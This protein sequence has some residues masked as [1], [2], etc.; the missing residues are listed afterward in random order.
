M[1]SFRRSNYSGWLIDGEALLAALAA[2][3]VVP[4]HPRRYAEHVTHRYP[5]AE[6]APEVTSIAVVGHAADAEVDCVVVEV[7]LPGGEPT[8]QRAD[9]RAYHCTLSCADGVKPMASNRLLQQGWSPI[10]PFELPAQAF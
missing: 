5:D 7:Q 6:S 1:G 4:L 9:G 10:E 8:S 3:G 2:Q